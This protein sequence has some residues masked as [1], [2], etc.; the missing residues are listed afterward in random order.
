MESLLK[1]LRYG[2]RNLLR[3]PG[4]AVV[5]IG[6]LTLGIGANTAI[7][8]FVDTVLLKTLPVRD[9]AQLVLFGEGKRRGNSTGSASGAMELYSW[10]EYQDFQKN[11]KVLDDL[12]AVDSTSNWK[13]ARFGGQFSD[14]KSDGLL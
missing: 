4:F 1:D 13:Y 6:S 10:R 8:S 9:P 14:G 5:A 11:N 12:I 7:F 2:C 3:N